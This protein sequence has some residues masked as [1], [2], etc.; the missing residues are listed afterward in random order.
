MKHEYISH[1]YIHYYV[2]TIKRL[3]VEEDR[4]GKKI[5]DL[6]ESRLWDGFDAERGVLPIPAR[7]YTGHMVRER[8]LPCT[9]NARSHTLTYILHKSNGKI[10][11]K[12]A[13]YSQ[14]CI[15]V[16]VYVNGAPMTRLYLCCFY[17]CCDGRVLGYFLAMK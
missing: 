7:G 15:C 1:T 14:N 8:S 3:A 2:C 11:T 6:W 13:I 17:F 5:D 10:T 4:R 12:P 9:T 16:C